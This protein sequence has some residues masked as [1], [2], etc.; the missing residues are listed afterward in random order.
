[1]H[2]LRT[3]LRNNYDISNYQ[4]SQIFF[5][6]KTLFS[7]ISKILIMGVLFFN[8]L[9]QY[10][11]AL[12][13]MLFLRCATGGLHFYTYLQCLIASIAYLGIALFLPSLVHL[14]Q[15]IQLLL[16]LLCI[17]I[18]Y[19]IGPIASKYRPIPSPTFLKRCKTFTCFF[20][21]LYSL[22]FYIMPE[23]NYLIIGFWIIILH[24][25]QLFLA[26]IQKKGAHN[27][28]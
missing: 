7:E 9:P 12:F 11:F 17:V 25:L 19:I 26:K 4:I 8:Q 24:S 5:L 13:I 21:F 22:L 2:I 3:Y 16:L 28:K 23:N 27:Q 14:S 10:L 15:H 1:M 6:F 18:C 20:I